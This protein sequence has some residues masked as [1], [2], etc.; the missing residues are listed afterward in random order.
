MDAVKF[1]ESALSGAAAGIGAGIVSAII[2][3]II[4]LVGRWI[5]RRDQ[6]RHIAR[7]IN[8]ARDLILNDEIRRSP[9]QSHESLE[10]SKKACLRYMCE[11]LTLMLDGRATRLSFDERYSLWRNIRHY[12]DSGALAINM[13]RANT[14]IIEDFFEELD[15][16]EWLELAKHRTPQPARGGRILRLLRFGR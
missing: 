15:T 10:I 1:W 3:G 2:F 13:S 5:E 7:I 8:R 14:E 4:R 6:I 12:T 9:D 16:I 11:T